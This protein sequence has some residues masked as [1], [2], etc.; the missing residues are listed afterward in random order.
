MSSGVR[1]CA[2][3]SAPAENRLLITSTSLLDNVHG[4]EH[5][6]LRARTCS[7]GRH[8]VGSRVHFGRSVVTEWIGSGLRRWRN[9]SGRSVAHRGAETRG[10]LVGDEPAK[11]LSV[12]F[13]ALQHHV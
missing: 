4:A 11:R 9:R 3:A 1:P 7:D 12:L 2:R 10:W 5:A 13:N 6:E 8:S